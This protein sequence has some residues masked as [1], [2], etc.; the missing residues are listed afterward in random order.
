TYSESFW[1]PGPSPFAVND[2]VAFTEEGSVVE[3]LTS[4]KGRTEFRGPTAEGLA[5]ALGNA[6]EAAPELF[7]EKLSLFL[8]AP[9]SYQNV[10]IQRFK[11]LWEKS[12]GAQSSI[13]W[14]RAWSQLIDF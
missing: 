6:A 5:E 8:D 9:A 2:L 12:E 1:G 11:L 10:L 4:F 7:L 14:E 13:V 3:K